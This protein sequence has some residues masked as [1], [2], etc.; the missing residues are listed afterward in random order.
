MAID[1]V[2]GSGDMPA[3]SGALVSAMGSDS[4]LDGCL[5]IGYPIIGTAD[6]QHRI[7]ALWVSPNRG[8]VVFD[9][10]EGG[11]KGDYA[12]RQDDSANKLDARLRVHRELVAGREI[13]IP[14][15]TV[16]YGP[17][18][19]AA[20][21][22]PSHPLFREAVDLR[23]DLTRLAW[24]SAVTESYL[25]EAL[26]SRT[27]ITVY[28]SLAGRR[29]YNAMLDDGALIQMSYLF[30]RSSELKRHRLAYMRAPESPLCGRLRCDNRCVKDFQRTGDGLPVRLRR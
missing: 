4:S 5:F 15:H 21:T 29:V 13:A 23:Q 7:D 27:Y 28:D 2:R 12:A 10:I 3:V 11:T 1:V 9:L 19:S 14:I 30:D 17:A 18:A 24:P 16:S 25:G 6:G 20:T 26:R 8:V 22:A